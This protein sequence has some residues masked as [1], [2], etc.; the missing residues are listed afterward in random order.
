[1][2]KLAFIS[3]V[4]L[5]ANFQTA[6]GLC[7]KDIDRCLQDTKS[8]GKMM[9][10]VQNKCQKL[11]SFGW[12]PLDTLFIQ[13]TSKCRKALR[14]ITKKHP[15]L[16]RCKCESSNCMVVKQRVKQCINGRIT[17]KHK[18][19]HKPRG[20]TKRFQRCDKNKNCQSLFEEV[21]RKCNALLN[22]DKCTIDCESALR[23]FFDH[24]LAKRL[25]KCACDGT[26]YFEGVCLMIRR[27]I[28]TMCN[29]ETFKD[30][31]KKEKITL[32]VG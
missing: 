14:R 27:R 8:C 30:Y 20:C 5:T 7:F 22:D 32:R 26:Q 21:P 24:P 11:V 4:F 29:S 19:H 18:M 13:C 15:E 3:M 28:K 17:N 9:K 10:H 12:Y 6:D 2:M 25:P 16:L 31:V 23:S 1:M